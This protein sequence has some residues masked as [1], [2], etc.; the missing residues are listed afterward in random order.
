MMQ[1]ELDRQQSNSNRIIEECEEKEDPKLNETLCDKRFN[2]LGLFMVKL[3]SH[4]FLFESDALIL[5][6]QLPNF[7]LNQYQYL[8]TSKTA[9]QVSPLSNSFSL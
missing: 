2:V 4:D 7:C 6:E 3:I 9:Y 8:Q 1:I 5:Q